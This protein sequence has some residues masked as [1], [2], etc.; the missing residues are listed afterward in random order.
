[1]HW[2]VEHACN[3]QGMQGDSLREAAQQEER[4]RHLLAKS[5]EASYTPGTGFNMA[6]MQQKTDKVS[7]CTQRCVAFSGLVH[8][9]IYIFLA[10]MHQAVTEA[11]GSL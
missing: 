8:P 10:T 3:A 11:P 4:R 5:Q 2:K 1:M 6:L 7:V 9:S